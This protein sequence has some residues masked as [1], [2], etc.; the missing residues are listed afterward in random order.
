M[1][2]NGHRPLALAAPCSAWAE[3]PL[4]H[5]PRQEQPLTRGTG[6]WRLAR[7]WAQRPP[8]CA[9]SQEPASR[10]TYSQK[11]LSAMVGP[12]D[13]EEEERRARRESRQAWR[14]P[15]G[16]QTAGLHSMGTT[17]PLGLPPISAA[18]EV[19]GKS[20][21]GAGAHGASPDLLPLTQEWREKAL[22]ANLLEPVLQRER[23]GWDQRHQDFDLY[24]RPPTFLELP[25]APKPRAG[26]NGAWALGGTPRST[27]RLPSQP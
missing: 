20:G 14:T 4:Q 15:I 17:R 1:A 24:T 10:F 7:S 23:W 11:Y 27:L 25:P 5:W 2:V 12:L 13:P 21:A 16:F 26:E 19:G 22:F 18:T 3:A 8:V 9:C 6:P